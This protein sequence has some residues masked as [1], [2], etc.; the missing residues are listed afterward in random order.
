MLLYSIE[1]GP[2]DT[3]DLS[4]CGRFF[5][6]TGTY[7]QFHV[8]ISSL[9]KLKTH[10]YLDSSNYFTQALW[11][12]YA[13]QKKA[14]QCSLHTNFS[15]FSDG[16]FLRQIVG[17]RKTYPSSGRDIKP[18]VLL[19]PSSLKSESFTLSDCRFVLISIGRPL[20]GTLKGTSYAQVPRHKPAPQKHER[21]MRNLQER[22]F[23]WSPPH[24]IVGYWKA[25]KASRGT[26]SFSMCTLSYNLAP[27][28]TLAIQPNCVTS[29]DRD[30]GF[31]EFFSKRLWRPSA[32]HGIIDKWILRVS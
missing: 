28:I 22:C 30:H 16:Q 18:G 23:K 27:W 17:M 9:E 1:P 4:A 25:V 31:R 12:K 21:E 24:T 5:F 11:S 14:W 10:F 6:L 8:S 13:A 29:G 20:V 15:L 32:R 19:Q 26:I 2:S 7:Q 3:I